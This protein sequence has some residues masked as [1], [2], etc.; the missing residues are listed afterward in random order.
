MSKSVVLIDTNILCCLFQIPGKA[1]C[2]KYSLHEIQTKLKTYEDQNATFIIPFP[3]IIEVGNHI[4]NT[5]NAFENA[6]KFVDVIE[7]IKSG[8]TPYAIF[9]DQKIL[10][11]ERTLSAI[12]SDWP[13]LSNQLSL[14][15]FLI[16][17][18]ADY[19]Q[20]GNWQVNIFTSDEGL[21][22]FEPSPILIPRRRQK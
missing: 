14:C 13:K 12:M 7:K 16:K 5:A 4:A 6:K 17:F 8:I 9:S 22:S 18:L 15:D 11:D 2:H 21:K 20:K 19:Y 1:T 3:V 10:W